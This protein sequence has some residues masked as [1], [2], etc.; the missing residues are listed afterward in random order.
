MEKDKKSIV[1]RLKWIYKLT[2]KGLF[3]HGVRNNVAKLGID[4]MPYYWSKSTFTD[5][6]VP[7]IGLDQEHLD[8]SFFGE[9][10]IKFIKSSV[11]GIDVEGKDFFK[12]LQNGERCL[13]LKYNNEIVAYI[14]IRLESFYFRKHFCELDDNA[15]YMH[16]LYVFDKFRGNNIATYLR[17]KCFELLS[18]EGIND[19]YGITEYFNKSSLKFQRKLN[20]L[21]HKS[22][23]LSI[24]LF[25]KWYKNMTLKNYK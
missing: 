14:F 5:F 12:Y 13:G 7:K 9:E 15:S 16:S 22:L 18:N 20:P 4:I 8:L 2:K 6:E 1:N 11:R 10:E 21:K 19:H 23:I 24:V 25:K 3:W 17:Y